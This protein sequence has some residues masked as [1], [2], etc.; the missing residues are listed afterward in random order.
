MK[1]K[2]FAAALSFLLLAPLC[3]AQAHTS[4]SVEIDG[5]GPPMILIPGLESPGQVWK[6]LIENYRTK[7]QIHALTLAGFAG[8][9][10]VAG[11]RLE[12]VK[13]E[14][15]A[16]IQ[17]NKLAKPVIVGHSL[18]GFLAFWI[19]SSA[20]DLAGEIISVDGLPFLP[21]LMDPAASV[22]DSRVQAE[23][24]RSL[25]A[26]MK[27]EQMQT[28]AKMSLTQMISDPKMVDTVVK[29]AERSDAGFVGQALYDLMTTDLRAE[30]AK[31]S[32]P[33]LLIGAG[34]AFASNPDQLARVRTTY[35]LQVAKAPQH[36]VVMAEHALHFIMLDDPQFLIRE[37]D[38]FLGMR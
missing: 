16:Y 31:I 6:N 13:D 21:A 32:C 26:S 24:M 11:L 4:F 28:M 7:Y 19:G 30:I 18:G 20:P 27:P 9:P 2:W 33:V 12:K 5:T 22:A 8:E 38:E 35:E 14:I 34:K 10:A 29:W 3:L 17:K 25:F 36:K 15:I 1:R 23:Q 37:I